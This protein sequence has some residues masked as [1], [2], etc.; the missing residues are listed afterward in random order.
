MGTL[1]SAGSLHGVTA[2]QPHL[3]AVTSALIGAAALAAVVL[4][5]L[6]RLTHYVHVMAHEGAHAVAGAALGGRVTGVRL[7]SDGTG[8]TTVESASG[9]GYVVT[10]VAGYLGASAFGLAA[11][12]LIAVGHAAAVPWAGL[13]GL[14]LL[15]YLVR[16]SGFGLAAVALTGLVLFAVA[17]YAPVGAQVALAYG[18]AWFLLVSGVRMVLMHGRNAGDAISLRQVTRVPRGLW[19]ALWLAGSAAAL[20][21]GGRMLI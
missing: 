5:G 6:S 14:V 3:P 2:L 13:A 11:A 9:A 7:H 20:L 17:R 1:S 15:G 4:P 12:K 10:S 8:L 18:I 16:R 19:A 21:I